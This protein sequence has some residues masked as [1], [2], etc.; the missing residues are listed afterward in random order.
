MKLF[1]SRPYLGVGG[2]PPRRRWLT[3]GLL[4]TV[5]ALGAALPAFAGPKA[6]A[7]K[8]EDINE[9]EIAGEAFIHTR[10]EFIK[11]S[12]DGKEWEN[13]EYVDKNKT[14]VIRGI[15]RA[16][17][18]TVVL[19]PREGGFEPYTLTLKPT[20]F[21]KTVIKAKGRTRTLAFRANFKVDLTK[22]EVKPAE[23][24]K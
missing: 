15:D 17:E 16:T 23:G 5:L 3:A 19:T 9:D 10:H 22:S 18:H 4:A 6:E 13:H 14:L 24:K 20:D 7:E 2:E 1:S 21:K 12:L 8:P 11:F